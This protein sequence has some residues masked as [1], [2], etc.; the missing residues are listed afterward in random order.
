[1]AIE[2]GILLGIIVMLLWGFSKI[3][4]K[5]AMGI[6]GPYYSLLY[7]HIVVG[8]LV[9]LI[10]PFTEFVLPSI[11]ISIWLLCAALIG[12]VGI[13]FLFRAMD[14]GKVSIVS[15][16]AHSA[17]IITVILSYLFL[18]ERISP[19]KWLAVGLMILG[20]ILIS[21][22]YSDIMRLKFSN[23]VPGVKYALIAMLGWGAFYFAV[24]PVVDDLGPLLATVYLEVLVSLF[25]AVPLIFRGIRKPGRAL[26]YSLTSGVCVAAASLLFNSAIEKS[27]VSLIYPLASSAPFISVILSFIMLGERIELN[28]KLAI[29][30]I[31]P[32]IIIASL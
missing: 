2:T 23:A 14:E 15:P 28:Q 5:K 24:K 17:A 22:R 21:F 7:E 6:I 12:A 8:F 13:S 27:A 20:T 18:G 26:K 31:I 3:P 16:I 32:G 1:M 29:L 4:A 19:L 10:I 25:I 9:L 11:R 30:L